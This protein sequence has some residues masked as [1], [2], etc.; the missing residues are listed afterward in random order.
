[1]LCSL[2]LNGFVEGLKKLDF[3]PGKEFRIVTVLLDPK[4]TN[5]T[6]APLS[7]ALPEPVRP[8]GHRGGLDVSD[9]L[10]SEHPR[11]SRRRSAFPTTTTRRGKEYIHPAAIT[12]LSPDGKIARYL[13]G[14]EYRKKTLQLGLVEASEGRV[15]TSLDKLI[16]FCFHYDSIE[17]RYAPIATRIMQ[18]GGAIS[19]VVLRRISDDSHSAR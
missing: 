13:Y 4:E 6:R 2:Q 5:E 7:R 14:L 3:T 18:V 10:G 9:R 8:P 12:L 15:G 17:G 19:V 1:M 16:L 11:A